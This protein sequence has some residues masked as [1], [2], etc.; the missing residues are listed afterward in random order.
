MVD[1]NVAKVVES[2]GESFENFRSDKEVAFVY[3]L[4]ERWTNEGRHEGIAEGEAKGINI[5]AEL[6][7][8]G[9]SLDEALHAINEKNMALAEA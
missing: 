9:L 8:S 2:L 3:S 5:L 4:R 6:I 7:R 1:E